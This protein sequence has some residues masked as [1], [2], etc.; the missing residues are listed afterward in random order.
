MTIRTSVLGPVRVLAAV[1]VSAFM[2]AGCG[3][4]KAQPA[5]AAGKPAASLLLSTEDLLTLRRNVLAT[6]PSITGSVQPER[7]ADLRAEVAAVVLTVQKENGDSVRRGDVLMRLDD[8]AIRES[9]VSAEESERAASQAYEQAQRQFERMTSLNK[10]RLVSL[11]QVEDAQSRRDTARSDK[12]AAKTR[13]V[14]ARQQLERTV[15]RAP[16]DGIVSSRQVSAGDTVQV[17]R[18][19]MKVIDPNSMRFEGFVSADSIGQLRVGQQVS[20]RVHGFADREFLGNISR[21]NP[22]ANATTRQVEVLVSFADPKQQPQV[23]GLYAEGRIATRQSSVLMLPPTALVRDGDQAFAWRV[24]EG[25]LHKAPLQVGE[26]DPRSGEF[27][28]QEGLSEGDTLLRY[29]TATLKEGQRI[30]L[31]KAASAALVKRTPAAAEAR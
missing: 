28:L 8:T 30:E 18:E 10:D 12:E 7:Q 2:L 16:F 23:A 22:A 17:G 4:G 13:V 19:L 6:G 21:V 27:V 9:L 20:F 14:T 26:R 3:K 5:G 25:A 24:H 1:A 11:Q 31:P 29:P 15:I